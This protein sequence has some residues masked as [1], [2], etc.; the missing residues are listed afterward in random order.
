MIKIVV[1]EDQPLI[2]KDLC[3]KI[4]KCDP[5]MEI[6]GTAT[7]GRA[8][9][10]KV[11]E[12]QPDILFTDIK[13]PFLSGLEVI[14]RLKAENRQIHTVIISGYRDFEFAREA[15]KLGVDEYLL[16]PLSADDISYV[17]SELKEKISMKKKDYNRHLL[18][19]LIQSPGSRTGH[20][21]TTFP[22]DCYQLLLMTAGSYPTFLLDYALPHEDVGAFHLLE[23][24]CRSRKQE[25]EMTYLF[26]GRH[27][28]ERI[29]LVCCSNPESTT[30]R[31]IAED[32]LSAS[33]GS[34]LPI[35]VCISRRVRHVDNIGMEV[36][37]MRTYT[38]R[39]LLFGRSSLLEAKPFEMNMPDLSS[40]LTAAQLQKFLFCVRN[41]DEARFQE[42]MAAL[43]DALE[44]QN[45]AQ[46][47]VDYCLKKLFK[48]CFPEQT[49]V[50]FDLE[51]DEYITYS[52]SYG[53]L[54]SYLK[55][56]VEQL[57]QNASLCNTSGQSD[58][59]RM[60]ADIQEYIEKNYAANIN[61]N[62]IATA[63]SLTPAYFSRMF[64]KYT[65]TRPIEYLTSVRIRHA[66]E[67]FAN[68][69]FSVRQVAEF[70]GYSDQYYFSKAFKSIT[71]KS[72]SEYRILSQP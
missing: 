32:V 47:T 39:N 4:E 66:C 49:S 71:G 28:N 33:S 30:A 59:A 27:E 8:A 54:F 68:S 16:K 57:M 61:I 26:S 3:L 48:D 34:G 10:E 70:C 52:K 14:S 63:F 58:S 55:F 50:D 56:F 64:K 36:Q 29:C 40:Y 37:I 18:E 60:A 45:A 12:L 35:T 38:E 51:I 17:L 42:T 22:Y 19:S 41:Q 53:D 65:G 5:D 72:P 2:L 20:I 43:L 7:D 46:I 9:Y 44:S 6:A 1:A 67:Y 21:N 25:G 11:A 31:Q 24:A 23:T 62:D 13:M 69:D 15:M